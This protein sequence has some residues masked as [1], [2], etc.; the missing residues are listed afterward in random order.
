MTEPTF[1]S[2]SGTLNG[3]NLK[4]PFIISDPAVIVV[5]AALTLEVFARG[6]DNG[7]WHIREPQ[8]GTFLPW[9]PLG[10]VGTVVGTPAVGL[11]GDGRLQVFWRG[12]NGSLMSVVQSGVN[13]ATWSS[14]APLLVGEILTSDPVVAR[15]SKG[16]LAVFF[17]GLKNEIRHIHQAAPND[18]FSASSGLGIISHNN[19]AVATNQ[20]DRFEIFYVANENVMWHF[21]QVAPFSNDPNDSGSWLSDNIWEPGIEVAGDP[22]VVKNKDGRLEVFA[23]GFDRRVYHA[24]QTTAGSGPWSDWLSLPTSETVSSPTAI[25]DR[26]SAIHVYTVSELNTIFLTSRGLGDWPAPEPQGSALGDP[27]SGKVIPVLPNPHSLVRVFIRGVNNDIQFAD[28]TPS[29]AEPPI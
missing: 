13:T 29:V 12:A 4:A 9:A 3:T 5:E 16:R 1:T 27:W 23:L 21:W 2:L 26:A 15:D 10:G 20:D 19:L 24:F 17:L 28:V 22:A 6:A 11:N 8:A 18:P 25:V 14:P 7:L